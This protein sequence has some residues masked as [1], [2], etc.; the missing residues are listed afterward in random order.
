MHTRHL[1]CWQNS[2]SLWNWYERKQ[3]YTQHSVSN[4]GY[5]V[6]YFYVTFYRH[7]ERGQ[8]ARGGIH[9]HHNVWTTTLL[10]HSE[11][12][13][14]EKTSPDGVWCTGSHGDA[15]SPSAR[16]PDKLFCGGKKKKKKSQ[17]TVKPLTAHLF[18]SE[19]NRLKFS[20]LRRA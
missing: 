16:W 12:P 8:G 20:C 9:D 19:S 4:T 1:Y 5:R 3:I 13:G 2:K 15:A 18:T 17:Q 10:V 14:L 7:K 11:I 6:P